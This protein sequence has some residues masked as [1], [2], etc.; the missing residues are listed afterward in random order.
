MR[1]FIAAA[2]AA[3]TF[4]ATAAPAPVSA[5]PLSATVPLVAK[6]APDA[7]A[8][9][10]ARW[11]GRRGRFAGRRHF[12]ARRY[13]HRRGF[14]RGYH[15]RYGYRYGR[16]YPGYYGY[17]Y[18]PSV[19]RGRAGAGGWRHHLQRP[20]QPWRIALVLLRAPLSFLRPALGN[21]SRL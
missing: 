13:G 15:P 16:G 9:Q 11:H 5:M 7:G 19:R 4:G 14:R 1:R 20:A 8:V 18:G 3:A 12:G 6:A 17:G 10:Q 21:V 2:L